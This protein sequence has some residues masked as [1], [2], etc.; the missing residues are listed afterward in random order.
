MNKITSIVKF[1]ERK[2][3]FFFLSIFFTLFIFY[4]LVGYKESIPSFKIALS[5]YYVILYGICL[6]ISSLNNNKKF[7]L[8]IVF[9]Y[10]LL[11]ALLLR[12]CSWC[13]LN[14][15]FLEGVDS[16]AYD[17][18]ARMGLE[19][20]YSYLQY[21][22]MLK[23]QGWSRDDFG[24][25]S[26][27]FW[28]YALCGNSEVGRE[29]LLLVNSIV[30]VL[31]TS[32]LDKLLKIFNIDISVRSFMLIAYGCFPFFSLTAAVGLKENFFSFFIVTSFYFAYSYSISKKKFHLLLMILCVCA[33]MFFRT[34]TFVMVI[35]SILLIPLSTYNNKK[36]I[37]YYIL[38]GSIIVA[39]SLN[40]VLEH[41]YGFS[42]EQFASMAGN[43]TQKLDSISGYA[44]WIVGIIAVLCGPFPNFNRALGYTMIF[45]SS[46]V[47]KSI[48]NFF[49]LETIYYSIK[50][51][52]YHQYPFIAF[53][54][55]NFAMLVIGGV[56]LDMRYF[57]PL[58][59]I[60]L[61]MASKAIQENKV[62]G[63]FYLYIFFI[64]LLM[65]L[66]NSR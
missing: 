32:Y 12:Y 33:C 21:L 24:M 63:T 22:D 52:D 44:K 36:K 47:F 42:L 30:I 56:F 14:E 7:L 55:M 43:R 20:N 40:F 10:S 28:V 39:I 35:C 29:I 5:V 45:S 9:V 49:T 19:R 59:P 3:L 41:L 23:N 1:N 51:F 38:I 17:G 46:L 58:F 27:V 54:L 62:S 57:I 48:I 61:I 65:L 37:L 26:I 60:A 53:Y 8:F 13:F 11:S 50:R 25:S 31:T 15:P 16:R 6:Y 2:V 66:Y 64:F 18:Y 34:A 4:A